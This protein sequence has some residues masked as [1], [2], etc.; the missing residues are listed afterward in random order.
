[1]DY[2]DYMNQYQKNLR[3]AWVLAYYKDGWKEI[4]KNFFYSE[5][6]D[7]GIQVD[8]FYLEKVLKNNTILQTIIDGNYDLCITE[9]N[10]S[11][12]TIE[13]L[14]KLREHVATVLFCYDNALIP[15]RHKRVASFFDLV[16]LFDNHNISKFEKWGAKYVYM[17]WAGNRLL[18]NSKCSFNNQISRILFIG[19]PHGSRVRQINELL[20]N[21]I[22]VSIYSDNVFKDFKKKQSKKKQ[23]KF[24]LVE[25]LQHLS[26]ETGRKILK[27]K[28]LSLIRNDNLINNEFLEILPSVDVNEMACLYQKYRLSWSSVFA[29]STGY[30]KN[31]LIT[32]NA[33]S[34]EIPISGGLQ[35][36]RRNEELSKFFSDGYDIVFYDKNNLIDLAKFYLFELSED[37]IL[38]MKRNAQNNALKNHTWGIRFK[39]I[40]DILKI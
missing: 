26:L 6:I 17:P 30:L 5:L 21:K 18:S 23:L 22:P 32:I 34:F 15:Y 9:S 31:P 20:L 24:P 12:F 33:R 37:K 27:G 13:D 1:M 16:W 11:Y 8:V 29:R 7:D 19:T 10:E 3:I 38:E 39:R 28:M 14:V 25:V 35:F 2:S 36:A 4:S 40:F